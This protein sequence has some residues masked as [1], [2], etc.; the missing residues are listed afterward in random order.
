M[1]KVLHICQS[2]DVASGGAVRVA[3]ELMKNLP[4][5]G[6]MSRCLFVYG[7]P[8]YFDEVLPGLCDYLGAQSGFRSL[9]SVVALIEYLRAEKP[10]IIHHHDGLTWTHLVTMNLR[11]TLKVGHAHLGFP[12]TDARL[13]HR[14]AG[15]IH[16]HT[17]QRVFGVSQSTCDTWI[18]GGVSE[19]NVQLLPNGVDSSVFKLGTKEEKMIFRSRFGLPLEAHVICYVGRLHNE[20]KGTDDF[21]RLLA[22]LPVTYWGL[23]AGGGEDALSLHSLAAEIGVADRV[24]FVGLQSQTNPCYQAS[25]LYVMTSRY[26]PFGLVVLEAAACGL[27][28]V[29]FNSEGG[30]TELMRSLNIPVFERQDFHKAAEQIK[31]FI[32]GS[33]AEIETL[34]ARREAILRQY[35]WLYLA[36]Q[37][38]GYYESWMIIENNSANK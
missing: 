24:R 3:A 38:A 9:F 30:G 18:R 1:I 32:E 12:K 7:S 23:I 16:K 34:L 8:G 31:E 6:I 29:G 22:L 10:D 15:W 26:E 33:V 4:H 37:A 25:D 5:Y 36:G 28:V 27:P 13:R 2:D 19:Q 11:Q 17:Y 14:F 20:V 35:S 21:I